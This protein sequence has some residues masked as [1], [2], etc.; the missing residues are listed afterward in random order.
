MRPTGRRATALM[1]A[2]LI[3]TGPAVAPVLRGISGPAPTAVAVPAVPGRPGA[4]ADRGDPRRFHAT[5]RTKTEGSRAIASCHNPYP[6]VDR[7]RLHIECQRW[8]DI[9]VD[10]APVKILPA[11]YAELTDRCWKEIRAVWVSHEVER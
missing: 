4:A 1:A 10:S 5:C 2:A 11:G 9:D 3:T 7:V 8:W 6:Y